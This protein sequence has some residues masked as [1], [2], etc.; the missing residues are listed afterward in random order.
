MVKRFVPALKDLFEKQGFSEKDKEVSSQGAAFLI[1]I[2]DKL[3]ILQ[4]DYAILD[5]ENAF[6]SIGS[7]EYVAIG[8]LKILTQ[9]TRLSPEAIIHRALLTAQKHIAT[10]GP[11]GD[12]IHT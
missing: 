6:T 1:G 11:P 2:H 3:F 7:G 10:I 9:N 8:A 4:G 5:V 12:V